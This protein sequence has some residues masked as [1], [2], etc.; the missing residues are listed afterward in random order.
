MW[1][2]C[3]QFKCDS[4]LVRVVSPP[5]QTGIV[6]ERGK[7]KGGGGKEGR[8]GREGRGGRERNERESGGLIFL[9]LV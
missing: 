3:Y 6:V 7:G 2:V 1:A 8:E 5:V 4:V 9:C